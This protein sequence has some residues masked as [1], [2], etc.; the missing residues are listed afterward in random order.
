MINFP[1]WVGAD[2]AK[3]DTAILAN[4]RLRYLAIMAS[5]HLTEKGTVASLADHCEL[6]RVEVHRFIREG[7]F[8]AKAAACI[9]KACGRNFLRREWLIF[10]LE[11]TDLT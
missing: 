4:R 5:I 7:A 8:S 2:K 3:R 9:E 10:P 6:D 11:V 1:A